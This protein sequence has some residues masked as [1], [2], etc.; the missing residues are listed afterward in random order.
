MSGPVHLTDE[1]FPV[2][3]AMQPLVVVDVWAA[4]CAPCRVLGP[5]VDRLAE[6]Y[7][8]RVTFAK[9]DV[10]QNPITAAQFN[11]QSIPSLLFF[12]NGKLVDRT[13][14][15]LPESIARTKVDQFIKSAPSAAQ[16]A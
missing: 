10:D 15:L 1:T 4:W 7:E 14:G 8:G 5:I 2:A 16:V 13:V 6:T 9:L 11:V 12:Q 3:I